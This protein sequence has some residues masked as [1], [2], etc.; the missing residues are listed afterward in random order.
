LCVVRD[1]APQ[2][3]ACPGG[4]PG[5]TAL[6][7]CH[8][9][10]NLGEVVRLGDLAAPAA[11]PEADLVASFPLLC[12]PAGKSWLAE[13]I[14][15]DRVASVVIAGCSPREHEETF[16]SVLAS[17]GTDPERL[18]MVNLRE[19]GEWL[20]G[21]PAE[22]TAQARSLVRAAL[23]RVRH[24]VAIPRR[25]VE[26]SGN[27]VVVGS[28]AAGVSAALAL[29]RRGRRVL[30]VEREP[31]LGGRVNLLDEVFPATECASCL[32]AP[33]LDAV[34]HHPN[35]EVL[36]RAEVREVQ[37]SV[38]NFTVRVALHP[39]RVDPAA[40]LGCGGCA[41]I[42]PVEL[43]TAD[44]LG[45]RSAVGIPHPGA[46]PNAAAVDDACLH[47]SGGD[48]TACADACPAGAIHLDEPPGE[49]AFRCGAVI[50]ATGLETP[51]APAGREVLTAWQLERMLHPSG[52]TL[53][54]LSRPDGS[55]PRSLLLAPG[56][57]AVDRLWPDELAK[58]AL[59]A[60]RKNPDVAVAVAGG[61][62]H[63]PLCAGLSAR[64]VAAGVRLVE[65]ALEGVEGVAEERE[66]VARLTG[67][68]V[69][70]AELVAVWQAPRPAPGTAEL[71]RRLGIA[72]S[73]DGFLRD[74]TT[75]L[76]PTSSRV[77]GIYVAGAAGGPR[78]VDEAVRDGLA[79]AGQVL[80]SLDPGE[81]LVL[82]PLAAEVDANRCASCGVCA[83][84]CPFGAIAPDRFLGVSRVE[85]SFCRGCGSCAAACP[86]A[87]IAAPHF[88]ALQL[89]EEIS[90]LLRPATHPER[91]T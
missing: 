51:P 39:R 71:A 50:L 80:S 22:A 57:G 53:G 40:C 52:P 64:L 19:Q 31:A 34:L 54:R 82:E 25:E 47:L 55:P 56:K 30:L 13:R 2:G 1:T 42:C 79:A 69:E 78:P 91:R 6:V 88:T 68:A 61:L 72:L 11:W 90:G 77:P 66:L 60:R 35:I 59:V 67:G 12:S 48:C 21:D 85:P 65:G 28:G 43:P 38:G 49:R 83:S 20:G 62:H 75:P 18:Q 89:A 70:R 41:S 14:R 32:M 33:A 24:H 8:C 9:G 76:D 15:L 74:R 17:G 7:F 4:V 86:A 45:R 63:T 46:F 36:S 87:A 3:V 10:P 5:R 44:G 23:A 58:L 81:R 16:R 29:G 73:E 84:V 37:G 27:A 26:V